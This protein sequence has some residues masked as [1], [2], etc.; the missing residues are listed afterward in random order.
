MVLDMP[1]IIEEHL[2]PAE[3]KPAEP[4]SPLCPFPGH[5]CD[6]APALLP[7]VFKVFLQLLFVYIR[8]GISPRSSISSS[9]NGGTG[10]IKPTSDSDR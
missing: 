1:H 7:S 2:F 8:S 4:A 10:G 3:L 5:C 9:V 6:G